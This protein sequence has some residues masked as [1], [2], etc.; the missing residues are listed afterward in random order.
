M[1][2]IFRRGPGL[3]VCLCLLVPS[4]APGQQKK[5]FWR[6]MDV[7]ARLDAEGRLHV[8]ELQAM[9]FT[10]DWNGGERIFRVGQGQSLKLESVARVD[11]ATGEKKTLAEGDLSEV[12][13]YGWKDPRTLRW[14]SRGH[15]DPEFAGT[16]IDYEIAYTLSGV[17]LR[18]GDSYVLDHDF[19]F[20]DR[21]GSIEKF[22]LDLELDPVWQPQ[23]PWPG[24]LTR[25]RLPPG[26]G[27]VVTL[28]LSYRGAAR[29]AVGRTGTT[30]GQRG[31]AFGALLAGVLVLYAVFRRREASLG[32]FA[33][34]PP[35]EAIDEA[36]LEKNVF[37]L[38]PEEVGA[39]WDESIGAPEV[40]AVLARL[41]A[42]KKIETD[43][44]GKKLTLRRLVPVD[45][46]SGYD[47]TLIEALFFGG[48][49]TDTD[50]IKAHYRSKGF[51]PA[52]KI[53]PGLE[54]KLAQ[55]PDFQDTMPRPPRWPT[56]MLLGSGALVL[57]LLAV[58]KK[59][60]PGTIVGQ[61]IFHAIVYAISVPMA[62]VLRKRVARLDLHAPALLWA[63][64]L[65][66]YYS[67]RGIAGGG[68]AG[69]TYLIGLLLLRLGIVN[70]IFNVAKTREG[71]KKT[72]R[73]KLLTAAREFF[74]RELASRQPNLHDR[75]YP[76]V[77]A[78]GLGKAADRWFHAYGAPTAALAAGRGDS[79]SSASTS[80][81]GSSGSWTGGGGSFGGAGASASWAAA[82]GAIASGVASPS[83]GGSGGG[84]GGGGGGSS[85]GGGGGGW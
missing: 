58:T 80:S 76:Y 37:S 3:L 33:P 73:R 77:I 14:R 27:V 74:K 32:R 26:Q 16:E 1:R 64:L 4:A 57:V 17:L 50:R 13:H 43:V 21:V 22:S 63:P 82:A 6:A 52:A 44:E 12:D 72:A 55:H 66:L 24:R 85:G 69:L 41:T 9:V 71:P 59:E 19:A 8:T 29:P 7:R 79:G 2:R 10:G 38:L 36:W 65:F 62:Y 78:F 49:E 11:P 31:A 61:M 18:Q 60:D 48:S 81:S 56:A 25:G 83:S 67:Y 34:L 42:E 39:L 5:L 75:W 68:Q 15:S 46:F 54:S 20:P 28:P 84:G 53:K 70:N 23:K 35:P 40:A 51:D 47:K 45:H 30:R